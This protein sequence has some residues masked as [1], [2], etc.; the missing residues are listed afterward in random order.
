MRSQKAHFWEVEA[1]EHDV[2]E[3]LVDLFDRMYGLEPKPITEIIPLYEGPQ[4][5]TSTVMEPLAPLDQAGGQ[6]GKELCR[7]LF[8]L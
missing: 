8:T 3:M 6:I 1:N 7:E 2:L 5:I 4:N